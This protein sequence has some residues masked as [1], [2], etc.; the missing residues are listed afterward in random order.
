METYL[1]MY[2]IIIPISGYVC[3]LPLV[4]GNCE[5]AIPTWGYNSLTKQCEQF[6]YGGC[7]GNEN[8]FESREACE[9][10]CKDEGSATF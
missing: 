2:Q 9:D 6:N 4:A 7:G 8:Q 3:Q 1:Q 5:A 10:Q